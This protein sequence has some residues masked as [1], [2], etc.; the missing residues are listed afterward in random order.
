[1]D[2][3]SLRI[4]IG[5]DE[6]AHAEV[7]RR[8]FEAAGIAVEIET[9]G[10]LAAYHAAV[11][12]RPPDIALVDLNLPEGGAVA[13][14]IAPPEAGT[15][16]VLVMTSTGNEQ[17]AVEVMKAGALDLVVKS[18]GAFAAMPRIVARALREWRLHQERKRADEALRE[19]EELYR[20]LFE[21][22][23]LGIFQS[24]PE[25]KAISV[26]PAFAR[27]FGYDSPEDAIRSIE[28]VA[29]GLFVDP[30]RRVEII[31]L[32]AEQPDLKVFENLY[33]RKD[34]SSFVGSL[35][36]MPIRDSDGR[37]VRIEGIIEDITERRCAEEQLIA[38]SN[39][40][41]SLLEVSLDPLVTIDHAGQIAD[42]NAAT[43]Q[44]TGYVRQ[45]LI[46]TNF[47]SYFTEPEQAEAGYR[48]AFDEG[49]VR[50]YPLEI[51]HRAG[52][53]TAVLYN[54]A[55]Y[56]DER[57]QIRG[58]FAAAR[59][60][61]ERKRA[62]QRAFELALERER[63]ALLTKF[64]QDASHEFRTPLTVMQ[65]N[66]YLLERL[67]DPAKRPGLLAQIREQV[68]GIARL[69]DLL[70]ER[71]WLDSDVPFT[72]RPADLNGL[73][74]AAAGELQGAAAANDLTLHLALT[75]DL[76]PVLADGN[77]LD[78][79]LHELLDNALRFTPAHGSV[80][81]CS[82][83]D[84]DGVTV[85]VQDTGPGIPPD[86]L[87]HIFERFYRQD[88]AHTTSGFGLGLPIARAIVNRHGGHLDVESQPGAGSMFRIRLPR[89][90]STEAGS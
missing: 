69:V 40:H 86:V 15:H 23:S 20:R 35:N 1:M 19:S 13:V 59:D 52:H 28:D 31:R 55:V 67:E 73:I 38:L 88:V 27:M 3:T 90:G 71:A 70:T 29:A 17:T 11:A 46:G 75:P 14:L 82:A 72:L 80:T 48:R 76:P 57:G 74:A 37:L 66:L 5:D 62:E 51:R 7:I 78:M 63:T 89:P 2:V 16:P 10:T 32:M 56:R 43:E 60:I 58:V 12:A 8:A 68:A 54:A 41:R 9:A 4:I 45:E 6:P 36:T 47:S 84:A 18:P 25:G 87:P 53:I 30:D 61:T 33:R 49:S 64:I 44:V 81:V 24:T 21:H 39:Y 26:N 22:A 34:G 77:Q 83:G 85:E 50:D 65:L 42:V 79:A